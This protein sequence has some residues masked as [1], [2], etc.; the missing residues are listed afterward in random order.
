[1]GKGKVTHQEKCIPKCERFSLCVLREEQLV[2]L[3]PKGQE[4]KSKEEDL[5]F[6]FE[7]LKQFFY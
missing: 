6:S 7:N 1:M 3:I 4:K 5:V 2:E